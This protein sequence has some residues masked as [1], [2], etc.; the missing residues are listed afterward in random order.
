MLDN[1]KSNPQVQPHLEGSGDLTDCDTL[2]VRHLKLVKF[3]SPPLSP[4]CPGGGGGA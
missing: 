1:Y 2:H 3:K 4:P